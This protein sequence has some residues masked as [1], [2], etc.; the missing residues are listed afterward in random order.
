MRLLAG[1]VRWVYTLP[2]QVVMNCCSQVLRN[3]IIKVLG[4]AM[5]VKNNEASNLDARP[6][7]RW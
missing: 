4:G 3:S 6:S 7:L 1:R 2:V 5:S